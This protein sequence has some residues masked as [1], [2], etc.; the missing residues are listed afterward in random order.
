MSGHR[1]PP[2]RPQLPIET[3]AHAKAPRFTASRA[4]L[5]LLLLISSHGP[6]GS[7]RFHYT[8]LRGAGDRVSGSLLA[9]DAR[10]VLSR[11]K[12]LGY[13]PIAIEPQA[14]HRLTL[15]QRVR[16]LL[17]RT[18]TTDLAVF[19]RQLAAL[20]K[21]GLP[22]V[23]ALQAVRTQTGRRDLRR[24]IG[25][26]ENGLTVG[27]TTLAE[28]LGEHPGVFDAVYVGLVHSG[29][30]SG[31]LVEVLQDL[32]AHLSKTARLRGQVVS[33]FIYPAFLLLMGVT[34]VFVLMAFVIPKFESLF[35]SF[36]QDL[37]LPTQM[38]IAASGWLAGFWWAVLLGVAA[39]GVALA[40]LGRNAA[41][42][43]WLSRVTLA[44]PLLGPLVT[45]LETAR[46]AR[47]LGAL[48]H[49]G[50]QIVPALAIA[51]RTVRNRAIAATLPAASTSIAGGGPLADAFEASGRFPR[52]MTDLV[53]TGEQT[54]DLTGML[55]ELAELYEDEAE[56]AVGGAV[57]LLEPVL[58]LGMGLVVSAI[59]GAVMLPILT[60]N[61]A[62]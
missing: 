15:D 8:A 30:E 59:V 49:G 53:R 47:T 25:E 36:G 29:E 18:R 32:S 24:V 39:F 13:H 38:M 14:E 22:I 58:I 40:G 61:G 4:L 12:Q 31:R 34:A 45:R 50:V 42:G 33:A 2:H 21:A 5:L 44:T 57:K 60:L 20:L 28:A 6:M 7:T 17:G 10:E 54:G 1:E 3:I 52:L 19:T 43:T 46:I 16:R 35:L 56:R 23:Q 11:V 55:Q 26:V 27:A 51:T 48:L 41:F 37:P 9:S 62:G